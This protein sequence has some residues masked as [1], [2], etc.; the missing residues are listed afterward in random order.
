MLYTIIRLVYTLLL[1][2]CTIFP[3]LCVC[4]CLRTIH[5]TILCCACVQTLVISSSKVGWKKQGTCILVDDEPT[6]PTNKGYESKKGWKMVSQFIVCSGGG[7]FLFPVDQI[8]L[9]SLT[10]LAFITFSMCTH[11]STSS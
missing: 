9:V 11:I 6:P 2:Y 3:L 7:D 8:L 1:F 10:H 5:V 4:V